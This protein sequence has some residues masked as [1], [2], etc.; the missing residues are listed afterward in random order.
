MSAAPPAIESD[1]GTW[2]RRRRRTGLL[3]AGML[4]VAGGCA[5]T[6][7]AISAR[8]PVEQLRTTGGGGAPVKPSK[9]VGAGAL[10]PAADLVSDPVFVTTRVGFALETSQ[11]GYLAVERLARSDDGGRH[12]YVTGSPF[13]VP[14]DFTALQFISARK[15]YVFGESGLLVTSDSGVRWTQ[16]ASLN[17]TLQRAIPIGENVWATFTR[18]SGPPGVEQRC[19]VGLAISYDGGRHWDPVTDPPI[20]EA[21]SPAGGDILARYSS[22]EAYV[23]SYG[24]T[25]GGLAF[26]SDAG[27][28]WSRLPDPCSRAWAQVD[29]AAPNPPGTL[30]LV[31][32]AATS[33]SGATRDLQAKVVY[34]SSDGGKRWTLMSSSGFAP[35]SPSPV[36]VLPLSGTV[37]QLATITSTTAWLGVGGLGVIVTFDSGRNW[38]LAAGFPDSAVFQS[39]SPPLPESVGVTFNN[40]FL[41]W[42]IEF[43]RG[44]W[45]TTDG[46]HWHL[47]DGS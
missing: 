26:T 41:G 46:V 15:G 7:V 17:G 1:G 36:G 22:D 43:R 33:A 10:V 31:C 29:M 24:P 34:Q 19:P 20:T 11:H 30:W 13:P 27:K 28:T 21:P 42:A 14:G 37:S 39:G 32:G 5:A 40:D 25:G 35:G 4:A 38:Q 8:R 12:W 3:C 44:V 2:R 18:C 6:A 47:L 23:I 16:V 45:A 9:P